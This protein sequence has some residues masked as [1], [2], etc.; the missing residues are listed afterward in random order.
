MPFTFEDMKEKL[1]CCI[2]YGNALECFISDTTVSHKINYG[3]IDTE[4]VK[5]PVQ[6]IIQGY[7]TEIGKFEK[8]G[9]PVVFW[10]TEEVWGNPETTK[11][12]IQ[13]YASIG[14]TA[15]RLPVNLW[16]Y[17][18]I[19]TGGT[20][21]NWLYYI[22]TVVR[23]MHES[24]IFCIIDMHCE[25]YASKMK[26]MSDEYKDLDNSPRF[27]SILKRW[28][29]LAENLKSFPTDALA[30]ELLNEFSFGKMYEYDSQ[31]EDECDKL[32]DIYSRLINAIRETGDHNADRLIGIDGY[33]GDNGITSA[34]IKC[35][36]KIL[37]DKR[38]FL[39]VTGYLLSEFTFCYSQSYGKKT[40][41]DPDNDPA[42]DMNRIVNDLYG[43]YLITSLGYNMVVAEYGTH[44]YD[45]FIGTE[46][47]IEKYRDGCVKL[48]YIE[49]N[50]CE[51]FGIPAFAWDSG[52]IVNRRTLAIKSP[53]L[54]DIIA[55]VKNEE[56]DAIVDKVIE[57]I[58]NTK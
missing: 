47:E 56:F 7:S 27:N 17:H 9:D 25:N 18:N 49:K 5:H 20:D 19:E 30:F 14:I 29:A 8:V 57:N 39:C 34:H 13:Y 10:S 26:D 2:N 12:L 54:F 41:L 21:E 11:E 28:V 43:I 22:H 3:M 37:N 31:Y 35:F 24:N 53:D 44:A 48:S 50:V 38:N 6:H 32:M 33:Q 46:E 58:I 51:K 23:W 52:Y 16:W 15:M 55:G 40:F 4:H 42:Y 1:K 45:D 36:D